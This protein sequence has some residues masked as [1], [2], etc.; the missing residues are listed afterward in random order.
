MWVYKIYLVSSMT[1]LDSCTHF[2]TAYPWRGCES[3]GASHRDDTHL[4]QSACLE[5]NLSTWRKPRNTKRTHTQGYFI[6]QAMATGCKDTTW[7]SVATKELNEYKW[8][9]S[10]TKDKSCTSAISA[11]NS[12]TLLRIEAKLA[13]ELRWNCEPALFLTFF[14][15]FFLQRLLLDLDNCLLRPHKNFTVAGIEQCF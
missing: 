6:R 4:I 7:A 12:K 14:F 13:E 3:A 9:I 2:S 1:T 15:F 8:K 10:A 11:G 5:V